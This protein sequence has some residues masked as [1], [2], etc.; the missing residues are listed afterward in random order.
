MKNTA[1]PTLLPKLA[2]ALLALQFLDIAVHVASD[3]AEPL[4]ITANLVILVWAAFPFSGRMSPAVRRATLPALAAY[5]LLNGVFLAQ[6]GLTN[7]AS[8]G[9]R[10]ALLAFVALTSGLM[11]VFRR[12]V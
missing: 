12:R 3:Q 8:G 6:H 11:L 5:L 2:L 4:R 7:P 1:A 9:L 10:L